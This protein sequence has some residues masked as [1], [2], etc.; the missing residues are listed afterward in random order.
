MGDRPTEPSVWSTADLQLIDAACDR[1]EAWLRSGATPNSEE[2][3]RGFDEPLRSVLARELQALER[4]YRA[5]QERPPF[6]EPIPAARRFGDYELLDKLGQGGMGEVFRARQ[7]NAD[8]IVVLKIIRRDRLEELPP[9]K[10]L[11]WIERFQSEARAA[12]QMEHD[13]IVPVYQVG[14][15]DGQHYYSMRYIAGRNLGELLEDGPLAPE[16]AADIVEKIARAI[17]HA[18]GRGILHRDLKP[19]NII[20]DAEGRPFI[21]DFGLAKWLLDQAVDLTAL[22]TLIGSPPY[23][24]PEQIDSPSTVTATADVYSLGATL[25]HMIAGRPPFLA[26]TIVDTLRQAKREDAQL[27]SALRPGL[28]R[29]LETICLRCLQKN[30]RRRYGSARELADDLRRFLQ[31]EPVRSRRPTRWKRLLKR[32]WP[33]AALCLALPIAAVVIAPWLRHDSTSDDAPEHVE[34]PEP[35]LG[36]GNH[37]PESPPV[38]Q[39]VKTETVSPKDRLQKAMDAL[40]Y[41]VVKDELDALKG[42]GELSEK[43]VKYYV[44]AQDLLKEIPGE[45]FDDIEARRKLARARADLGL[46]LT[47]MRDWWAAE[48]ALR[49]A[50]SSQEKLVVDGGG[51][52]DDEDALGESRNRLARLQYARSL[53]K[54]SLKALAV[55]TMLLDHSYAATLW[56]LHFA[57]LYEARIRARQAATTHQNLV[58]VALQEKLPTKEYWSHLRDDRQ[59]QVEVA[60]ALWQPQVAAALVVLLPEMV[61]DERELPDEQAYAGEVLAICSWQAARQPGRTTTERE[62]DARD[63]ARHSLEMLRKASKGGWSKTKDLH[64]MARSVL[65]RHSAFFE[66]FPAERKQ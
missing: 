48:G 21:T 45:P 37:K 6:A 51:R 58:T 28:P 3:L 7:L 25:Y 59:T 41:A 14:E 10:R 11:R 50:I 4:A 54:E 52:P 53:H 30:P 24:A 46:G 20:I 35:P 16:Q 44:D 2:A 60:L 36:Q 40:A 65:V 27:P 57:W 43:A 15:V 9:S 1:F 13:N 55:A 31:H 22:G 5:R 62:Q 34:R 26:G 18:H 23:M 47:S 63:L 32:Y 17:D 56:T 38:P 33:A 29:D 64:A 8:R 12:A 42:T 61:T 66:L 19:R 49:Q 39:A